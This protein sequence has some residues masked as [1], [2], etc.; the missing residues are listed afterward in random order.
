MQAPVASLW[1][2]VFPVVQR[3]E[4]GCSS[5]RA[6]RER[7]SSDANKAMGAPFLAVFARSGDFDFH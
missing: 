5:G 1:S 6:L 4:Q 2:P 7:I 3:S